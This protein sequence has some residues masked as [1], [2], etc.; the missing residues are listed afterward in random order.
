[1]RTSMHDRV[2]MK[3]ILLKMSFLTGE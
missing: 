1:M 2:K 3:T